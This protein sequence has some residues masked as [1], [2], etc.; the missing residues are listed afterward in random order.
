MF[1]IN[2]LHGIGLRVLPLG[3]LDQGLPK[4]QPSCA[5]MLKKI[6]FLELRETISDLKTVRGLKEG[7]LVLKN[8]HNIVGLFPASCSFRK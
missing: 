2:S 1:S 5:G 4:V 6:S 8:V 7:R 3:I